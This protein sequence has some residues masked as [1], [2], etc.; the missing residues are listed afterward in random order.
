MDP[1]NGEIEKR[2]LFEV[3]W[4]QDEGHLIGRIDFLSGNF[5]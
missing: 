3:D 5:Q 4:C 2:K 1:I